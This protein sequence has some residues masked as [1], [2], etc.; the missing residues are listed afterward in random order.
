MVRCTSCDGVGLLPAHDIARGELQQH[1]PGADDTPHTDVAIIGGGIGG[2][3]LALALQQRGLSAVV[4]ERDGH[5]SERM[6]G[7]ALT[8]QQGAS[9]IRALGLSAAVARL[10]TSSTAHYCF[11]A[12]SGALIGSHGRDPRRL[13]A[14]V[15]VAFFLAAA[16]MAASFV[17]EMSGDTAWDAVAHSAPALTPPGAQPPGSSGRKAA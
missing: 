11:D 13:A 12:K 7:Y 2:L 15:S 14:T 4:Y 16:L 10:G 3:A 5:F 9:A 6:Q 17:S 8:L 1:R